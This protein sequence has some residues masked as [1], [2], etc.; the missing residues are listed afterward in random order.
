M[1]GDECRVRLRRSQW[2][3]PYTGGYM[4]LKLRRE[5]YAKGTEKGVE[6]QTVIKAMRVDRDFT[7]KS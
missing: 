1:F 4:D 6:T 3:C 7:G 2:K 5:T